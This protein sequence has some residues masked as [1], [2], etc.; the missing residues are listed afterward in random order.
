MVNRLKDVYDMLFE[1]FGEQHWWPAETCFEVIIGAILTQ[2]TSWRNVEKAMDNLKKEGL[3]SPK[4]LHKTSGKEL[5]V[6][7]KPAGYY[8]AKAK[9]IGEFSD[10]LFG[11]FDGNLEA[12]LDRPIEILRPEL[13]SIWG[14][15]PETAD[16]I[17]LYAAGKPVFVVDAYTKRIFARMGLTKEGIGYE[18]LR[19]FSEDNL[20]KNAQVFNEFHAL[21]VR[22]GKEYCKKSAPL[23]AKCPLKTRCKEK[24]KAS[25]KR[26]RW[27]RTP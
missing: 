15:G 9:K 17:L 18:E 6:L 8:N 23:C 2:S 13:L 19:K 3:M 27:K 5:A 16:S 12:M 21:L 1:R 14:I 26:R 10:H 25:L 22:L 4:K 11:R 24:K 20:P 7:I